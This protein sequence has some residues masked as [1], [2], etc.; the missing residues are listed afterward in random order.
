MS[1]G[2]AGTGSAYYRIAGLSPSRLLAGDIAYERDM[3]ERILA[4]L[5]RLAL[6]GVEVYIGD[7]GRAYLPTTGLEGQEDRW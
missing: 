5:T 3:A 6:R 7:P 4:L 2:L 1:S